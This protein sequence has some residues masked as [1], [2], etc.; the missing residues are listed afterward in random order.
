[1]YFPIGWP[2]VIKVAELGGGIIIRQVTCNRD[3]ILFAI[4]TD[5]SL[6][7]WFCKVK[8]NSNIYKMFENVFI[9]ALCTSCFS[10]S[11]KRFHQQIWYKCV[12]GME[13][14]FKYDRYNSKYLLL[15]VKKIYL[16]FFEVI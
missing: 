8:K 5:D 3:R 14:R 13:T 7:I 12:F 15:F 2:K 1:M 16:T 4:L 9:L 11:L 6:A 10:T